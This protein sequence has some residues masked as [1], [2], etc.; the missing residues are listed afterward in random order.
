MEGA[1]R[2]VFLKKTWVLA[3][4]ALLVCG[5][6]VLVT[7]PIMFSRAGPSRA[8]SAISNGKDSYMVIRDY[9]FSHNGLLPDAEKN[10]NAALR[11]LF[12]DEHVRDERG[13]SLKSGGEH[14]FKPLRGDENIH[15]VEALK[16]GELWYTYWVRDNGKPHNIIEDDDSVPC[17]SIPNLAVDDVTNL[18][19]AVFSQGELNGQA[20]IISLDGAGSVYP[21]SKDGMLL[22][23]KNRERIGVGRSIELDWDRT[24]PIYPLGTRRSEK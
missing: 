16:E 19:D 8:S 14:L 22:D 11:V 5:S 17:L 15:G 20:V 6:A 12:E 24:R 3:G 21:L 1:P 2:K 4:V 9:A 13:F 18:R 23:Y 7:S 10:A